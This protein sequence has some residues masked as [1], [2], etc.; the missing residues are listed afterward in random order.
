MLTRKGRLN[1]DTA[2]QFE[3]CST[4]IIN[5]D[6]IVR[7]FQTAV[8]MHAQK[9][10]L[11]QA[12]VLIASRQALR[13]CEDLSR[14][15]LQCVKLGTTPGLRQE[16]IGPTKPKQGRGLSNDSGAEAFEIARAPDS[17]LLE[18]LAA[19]SKEILLNLRVDLA[20]INRLDLPG[21]FSQFQRDMI[22]QS[23]VPP[24]SRQIVKK[25]ASKPLI[26]L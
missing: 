24:N 12:P 15:I 21:L 19:E 1:D 20:Q 13:L 9:K 23:H 7:V 11:G 6:K 14:E 4:A 3:V 25:E 22:C 17:K 18:D 26:L 8:F 16:Q 10:T 5:L 2:K